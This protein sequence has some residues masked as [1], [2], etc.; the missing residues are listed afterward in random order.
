MSLVPGKKKHFI[1]CV[2][3]FCLFDLLL[4]GLTCLIRYKHILKCQL[5]SP[6][7]DFTI[8]LTC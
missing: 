4:F 3:W 6:A 5:Q 1:I 8:N 7:Q 2:A